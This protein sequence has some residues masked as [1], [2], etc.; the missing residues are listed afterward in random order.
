VPTQLAQGTYR[1]TFLKQRVTDVIS[2]ELVPRG[3]PR[4]N[5]NRTDIF[6]GCEITLEVTATSDISVAV[7]FHDTAC[8]ATSVATLRH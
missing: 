6:A 8:N 7:A 5:S 2:E 4:T 3:T 1:I